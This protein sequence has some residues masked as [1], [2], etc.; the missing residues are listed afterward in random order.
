MIEIPNSLNSQK[1]HEKA[2]MQITKEFARER[3][4]LTTLSSLSIKRKPIHI[5]S[6]QIQTKRK[7]NQKKKRKEKK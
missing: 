7:E 5:L 2:Q 6:N 4:A 1:K 3:R